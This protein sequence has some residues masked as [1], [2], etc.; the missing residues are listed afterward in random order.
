MASLAEMDPL[1][2]AGFHNLTC[3]PLCR[4]P[5]ELLLDI[6][7]QLDLLSIQCLRRV[8]RLFL[9][10]YSSPI[11]RNSY[12]ISKSYP[13]SY[14]HWY[15]PKYQ[16]HDSWRK[17]LPV[18]LNRDLTGYCEDCQRRRIHQSWTNKSIAL[19]QE[20]LHCSGCNIDHPICLFSKIQRLI[21]PITRVCIGREGFVRLCY[22]KIITWEKIIQTSLQLAKLNTNSANV[23]LSQCGHSSH[24]PKHHNKH[25]FLTNQQTIC[26]A[27]TVTG[28]R[29]S[30]IF[31]E[32]IWYGHLC[33]PDIG[34]D[35]EGNNNMAIPYLMRQQL[36]QFRQGTAEFIV[37]EIYPGRL[38]EMNCFDPNR[39]S[40]LRYTGVEQLPKGWQLTPCQE[41]EFLA[42]LR[43]LTRCSEF[44]HL[45][46][47]RR[48]SSRLGSLR[49]FENNKEESLHEQLR[50]ESHYI[51]VQ[52]T[53][54]IHEGSSRVIVCIEPCPTENRCL[55]IRY[56]RFIT[57]IP[58]MRR[59]SYITWAW[60]Q[61]L[62]PD[63]YNLTDDNETFGI[64][65]CRQPNCK[66]Y[67]KYLR[68]APFPL[69]DTNRK[70]QK[71]CP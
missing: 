61:A 56:K 27:I 44:E 55:Q 16:L 9:R 32:L 15:E 2:A 23:L 26:P 24:F 59:T 45:A 39:C 20:Y 69:S 34:F 53:G 12:N 47:R 40:C 5:E 41:F 21:P 6:M 50:T 30:R 7:V 1:I 65:W 52:T 4:L 13:A 42:G 57:I 10:L 29:N 3:S 51:G 25:P 11:F 58:E 35:D 70:C 64:L 43:T 17:T 60:C 33:L 68:K 22:H 49:S 62:D 8:S 67:Y 18:L 48:P 31:I 63:S 71:Y 66:N 28:N 46:C 19:T 36:R 54:T 38:L 14:E 37:P